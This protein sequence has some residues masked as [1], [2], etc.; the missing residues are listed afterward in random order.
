MD[1][2]E[3]AAEQLRVLRRLNR[4]PKI[5]WKNPVE[6]CAYLRESLRDERRAAL[7]M[8]VRDRVCPCCV[9]G[10][11]LH[12]RS[13]VVFLVAHILHKRDPNSKRVRET[14]CAG[15]VAVCR[16]CVM[17]HFSWVWG[18][19]ASRQIIRDQLKAFA[20]DAGASENE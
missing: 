10:P 4:N 13:W 18:K 16:G 17:K 5:D 8:L 6:R 2:F 12:S 7:D 1:E 20:E 9:Q 15:L 14:Q 3:K 11:K 19:G